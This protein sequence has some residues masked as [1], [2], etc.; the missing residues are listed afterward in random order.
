MKV[1]VL[2]VVYQTRLVRGKLATSIL[3]LKITGWFLQTL[4]L[5]SDQL[6]LQ[7]WHTHTS[8]V[9]ICCRDN[10]LLATWGEYVQPLQFMAGNPLTICFALSPFSAPV[11]PG[12]LV[13]VELLPV[14]ANV[15]PTSRKLVQSLE[16]NLK[17]GSSCN[18]WHALLKSI[19]Y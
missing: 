15:F 8:S 11:L 13:G 3:D 7:V 18:D 16:V 19:F 17:T 6:T 5:K 12:Q 4:H 10:N 9:W 2:W 1:S 14:E